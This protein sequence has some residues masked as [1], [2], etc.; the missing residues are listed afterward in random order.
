M[1]ENRL[2]V[3]RNAS[4]LSKKEVAKMLGIHETTYGKYELGSRNPDLETL[5]QI[6]MLFG[7][8]VDYLIG[9]AS[10]SNR[11]VDEDFIEEVQEMLIRYYNENDAENK[12]RLAYNALDTIYCL[13]LSD[14]YKLFNDND[15]SYTLFALL[16]MRVGFISV[17][18]NE[19]IDVYKNPWSDVSDDDV[20]YIIRKASRYI[21]ETKRK[22]DEGGPQKC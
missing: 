9:F 22:K 4:G 8:T 3:A 5:K 16:N 20:H 19:S 18:G 6:A 15:I 7:S 13:N 2:Q 17:T 14:F 10:K 11:T 21:V 1:L 12:T